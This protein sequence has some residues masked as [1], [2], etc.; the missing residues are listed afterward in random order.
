[1]RLLFYTIKPD[2]SIRVATGAIP[3]AQFK[4]FNETPCTNATSVR[5]GT[6]TRDGKPGILVMFRNPDVVKTSS[7]EPTPRWIVHLIAI[8]S[9]PFSAFS[10]ALGDEDA[11]LMQREAVEHE[12]CGLAANESLLCVSAPDRTTLRL[13]RYEQR[14]P[15]NYTAVASATL[16]L[17]HGELAGRARVLSLHQ[18]ANG[19]IR[20]RAWSDETR[21][22]T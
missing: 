11:F 4:P 3:S 7:L 20:V 9:S 12:A 14:T 2:C 8:D 16:T 6:F 22:L 18:S 10:M 1:D 19:S 17:R 13:D 21:K 5:H 15:Q